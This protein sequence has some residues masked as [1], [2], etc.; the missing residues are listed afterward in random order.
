MQTD[1]HL[2]FS[3]RIHNFYAVRK[4][5]AVRGKGI[6]LTELFAT[7]IGVIFV[8]TILW[9]VY[10]EYWKPKRGAVEKKQP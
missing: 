5:R 2:F 3:G 4:A 1:T 7:V 6:A 9:K 8:T 10:Q